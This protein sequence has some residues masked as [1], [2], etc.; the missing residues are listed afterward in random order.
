MIQT[1]PESS[2]RTVQKFYEIWCIP[3]NWRIS[4]EIAHCPVR[5]PLA[6]RLP[7]ATWQHVWNSSRPR[8]L[9]VEQ[10]SRRIGQQATTLGMQMLPAGTT[11]A[12]LG[13]W[14]WGLLLVAVSLAAHASGLGLIGAFLAKCFGRLFQSSE[15]G[16]KLLF[17]FPIVIG[18]TS[19]LLAVL[20]GLEASLWAIAYV[21]LGASPDFTRAVYYSLQMI[22]TLGADVVSIEARWR[23]MG[24]L[25]AI[26][27]MLLFGLST[28][29]LLAVLQR[30]WPFALSTEPKG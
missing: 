19:L 17:V 3:W 26:S 30:V 12:W 15:R 28:A 20:H 21:W 27:G 16:R 22:T 14:V 9:R 8:F 24:P 18:A 6:A 2:P 23:L 11:G 13:D 5:R 4:D 29:F 10:R 25:E 1:N 7:R